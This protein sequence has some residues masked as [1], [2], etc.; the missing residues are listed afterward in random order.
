M[1][2]LLS[3]DMPDWIKKHGYEENIS[4][5]FQKGKPTAK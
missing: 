5:R 1:A 4:G 3:E 2:L